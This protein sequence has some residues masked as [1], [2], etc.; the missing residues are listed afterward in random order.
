MVPSCLKRPGIAESAAGCALCTIDV[1]LNVL[2]LEAQTCL[3]GGLRDWVRCN[4]HPAADSAI[5]GRF[6]QLR[7]QDCALDCL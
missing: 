7:I 2:C 3:K 4:A 6:R 5:L 1:L